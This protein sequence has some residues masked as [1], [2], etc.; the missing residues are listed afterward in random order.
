MCVEI[1]GALTEPVAC[2]VDFVLDV[3]FR[4]PPTPGI[5]IAVLYEFRLNEI[6]HRVP[7]LT[8]STFIQEVTHVDGTAVD[9][10]ATEVRVCHQIA[11]EH[12][13]LAGV[14]PCIA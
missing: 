4:T 13:G 5:E 2:I 6:Y 10:F 14:G 1:V 12:R 9:E 7:Y 3:L 8:R 11:E